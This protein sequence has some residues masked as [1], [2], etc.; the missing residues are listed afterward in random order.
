MATAMLCRRRLRAVAVIATASGAFLLQP[1]FSFGNP[2]PQIAIV[3]QRINDPNVVV[4]PRE[5]HE[6][7]LMGANI[8]NPLDILVIGGGATGCGVALDGVT[9]GLRVGLVEREDF[10]SGTSSRSTKL[11]HG[12]A[13]VAYCARN[14]Y[15]ESAIDFIARR[16]RLAFLDT[17]AAGRAL[18]RI[19]EILSAEHGW[20]NSRQK[21]ELDKA[22]EF[23]KTFKCSEIAQFHDGKKQLAINYSVKL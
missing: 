3:R 2:S 8:G 9:R 23:L 14:E 20:D 17:R 21:Q 7:A 6:S 12:E 15:C 13:E 19:I 16:S 22:T 5:I 11:I 10:S 18:P 4:P 1:S